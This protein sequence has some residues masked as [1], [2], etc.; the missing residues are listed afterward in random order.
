MT[1]DEKRLV[2]TFAAKILSSSVIPDGMDTS[3][4]TSS[5]ARQS[6]SSTKA[7]GY[8]DLAHMM[9][10]V[11]EDCSGLSVRVSEQE[12]E[13]KRLSEK[14]EAA[15]S[16]IKSLEERNDSTTIVFRR[17]SG[18]LRGA[19]WVIVAPT[20]ILAVVCIL[21]AVYHFLPEETPDFVEFVIG[22]VGLG[23]FIALA[24]HL[25]N[26]SKLD[27]RVRALEESRE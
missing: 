23:A 22:L 25:W 17:L 14:L 8:G 24:K 1:N 12:D 10:E 26:L 7:N 15:L 9:K 2:Q 21:L 16:Q 5:F 19:F 4:S 20:S 11:I 6:S 27:Q 18:V 3:A 13:I